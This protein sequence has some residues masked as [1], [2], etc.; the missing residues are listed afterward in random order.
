[1]NL[2]PPEA[3]AAILLVA[4]T[5]DRYLSDEEFNLIKSFLKRRKLFKN[6]SENSLQ[7]M[8]DK[9]LTIIRVQGSDELLETA[10]AI[11]P[12]ELHNTILALTTDLI[13]ADGQVTEEEKLFLTKLS[14]LL[15][16]P[17]ETL[18]QIISVMLIKNKG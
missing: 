8:L 2:E 14:K 15:K 4:V 3:F 10:T 7:K 17:Q 1:M 16:I 6:Y 12:Y 18:K 13:L 5:S 9:L 11:L